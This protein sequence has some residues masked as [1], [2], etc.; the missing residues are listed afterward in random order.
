MSLFDAEHL[1][2]LAR[3]QDARRRV[4]LSGIG[5]QVDEFIRGLEADPVSLRV[6]QALSLW[7]LGFG[8]DPN[9]QSKNFRAYWE[10]I[11]EVPGSLVVDDELEFVSLAD[12]RPGLLRSCKMLGIQF[13]ELG[14][15]E[16]SAEPFNQNFPLPAEPF[17]FR[18]DDGRKN[19][20]RRPDDCRDE[21]VGDVLAGTA[22]EGVF[23]Y[24]HHPTIVVENEHSIDL[25][26]TVLRDSRMN[27]AFLEV[28]RGQVR[29]SLYRESD[30]ASPG[31]GTLRLRRK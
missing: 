19:H 23:A 26:R 17:W 4:S 11:P 28:W 2:K 21:L 3:I 14:F 15:S 16:E 25:P 5:E 18:H 22:L 6:M 29:I 7:T 13:E 9:V 12:P 1:V 27:C 24:A 20:K 10:G 8:R 30:I 31:C